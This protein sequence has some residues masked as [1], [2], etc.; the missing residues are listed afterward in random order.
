MYLVLSRRTLLAGLGAMLAG[1]AWMRAANPDKASA[2][3]VILQNYRQIESA[4]QQKD[5]AGVF[6]FYAPTWKATKNGGSS[7][8]AHNRAALTEALGKLRSIR[9]TFTPEATDLLG[10]SFFVRYKKTNQMEFPF[11]KGG[12]TDEYNQDIWQLQNG[13]WRLVETQMLDSSVDQA[14]RALEAQKKMMDWQDEQRKSQRCIGGV[15][16][17]CGGY[18]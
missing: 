7:D 13:T 12:S 3:R 2:E 15:G 6:R 10:D 14:V 5:A 1:A 16:Y 18:R 8:L 17:G 11:G 4:Y 9:V